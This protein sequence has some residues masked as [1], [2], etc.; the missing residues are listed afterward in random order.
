MIH[1]HRHRVRFGDC[2]PAGIVYFPRY[3]DWF[4]QAME[5]W[6]DDALGIPY[7][8]CITTQR[9]G[10]PTVHTEAD[11][12]APCALGDDLGIELTVGKIGNASVEL[13]YRVVGDGTERAR[14]R[15][16]V[17]IVRLLDGGGV[18]PRR[19]DGELR[20]AIERFKELE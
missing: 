2:D 1:V 20:A 7:A 6:F 13:L 18:T 3:F 8:D 15:S 10:F 16:V 17:C 14:G 5:T 12:L 11:Y 4:H 19:L 9:L